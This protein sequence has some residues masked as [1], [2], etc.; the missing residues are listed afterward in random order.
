[1][2]PA[3]LPSG[4]QRLAD[5][6]LQPLVGVREDQPDTLQVA[7]HEGAQELDPEGLRFR[8]VQSQAEDLAPPILVDAGARRKSPSVLFWIYSISAMVSVVGVACGNSTL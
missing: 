8:Q 6:C 4:A 3:V 5:H 7:T 1:M 2:H